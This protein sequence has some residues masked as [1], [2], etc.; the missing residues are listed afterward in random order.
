MGFVK[1]YEEILASTRETADFYDAEMLT[2]FWETR[3]ETVARLLPAP[4]GTIAIEASLLR[5]MALGD[6]VLRT[7]VRASRA[8]ADSMPAA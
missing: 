2:V 5:R 8:R 3:P 4:R 1:T 7:T 6:F